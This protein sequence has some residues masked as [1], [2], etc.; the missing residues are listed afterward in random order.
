MKLVKRRLP[1]FIIC[2]IIIITTINEPDTYYVRYVLNT[3]KYVIRRPAR[4]LYFIKEEL[5]VVFYRRE[6]FKKIFT[7]SF[8]LLAAGLLYF[9]L[10]TICFVPYLLFINGF[11]TY[12]N[13]Y[14]SLKGFYI[15]LANLLYN[16]RKK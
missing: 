10:N 5:K 9:K 2:Y 7:L 16:K 15:I 14:R 6:Y 3:L 1:N 8:F 11:G 4:K 13:N 12:K